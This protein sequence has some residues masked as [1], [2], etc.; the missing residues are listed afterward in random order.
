MDLVK[1]LLDG[2]NYAEFDLPN[3]RP[4]YTDQWIT[5]ITAYHNIVFVQKGPNLE[6]SHLLPPHPRSRRQMGDGGP[7]RRA[8]RAGE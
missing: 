5:S 6:G 2:L 7:Y 3:Y 4:S 8:G 1:E